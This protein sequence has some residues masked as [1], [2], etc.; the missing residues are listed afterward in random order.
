MSTD[1]TSRRRVL[2]GLRSRRTRA[3]L[4]M[5]VVLGLGSVTTLAYWTDSATLTG[6]SFASGTIDLKL[7]GSTTTRRASAPPSR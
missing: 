6:G 3:L 7:D 4:S 1:S 5:G 2:R